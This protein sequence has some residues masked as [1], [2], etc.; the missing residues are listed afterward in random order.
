VEPVG[1]IGQQEE[2]RPEPE[3][4]EN[5]GCIDDKAIGCDPEDA[6]IES[7]AKDYVAT[8]MTIRTRKRSVP[9]RFPVDFTK[10]SLRRNVS[11]CV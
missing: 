1:E 5:V 11:R 8:L 4:R 10:N 2:E 3:D 7:T 9:A 6:G